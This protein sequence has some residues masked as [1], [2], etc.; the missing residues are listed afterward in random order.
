MESWIGLFI[1]IIAIV[2]IFGIARH[3]SRQFRCAACGKTHWSENE[4]YRCEQ[5]HTP[6]CKDQINVVE[7]NTQI[8]RGRVTSISAHIE[9]M[10]MAV[11]DPCGLAIISLSSMDKSV[12][13]Y[14]KHHSR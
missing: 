7:D 13:Y 10:V 9:S 8:I 14:C 12:K 1:F 4:V 11:D 2:L 6:F 3:W 5:C